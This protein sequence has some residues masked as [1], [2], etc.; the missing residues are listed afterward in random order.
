MVLEKNPKTRPIVRRL[1]QLEDRISG[2]VF[3]KM[4]RVKQIDSNS[5]GPAVM[6]MLYS[7]Y[8]VKVSQRGLIASL[9]AKNKIKKYGLSV[10]D[11]ARASKITGKGAFNFWRKA[12]GK[13]SDLNII[14]NKYKHP[15]AVEW[16]GVFYEE[17]DEDSGHYCV[18]T[19]VD[20]KAGTLRLADPYSHF[21]GVD[22]K[23][24][25]KVFLKR[26][27]DKNE[28]KGRTLVDRR[29]MFLITPKGESWPKKLGMVKV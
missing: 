10:R 23:F 3:P 1:L 17:E 21:A 9:R 29:V 19:R 15:V 6:A 11:M 7:Q 27:W 18:I 14:V 28:I 12:N 25:I 13:I 4:L 16:Q 26:W 20:K 24:E 22:R 2:A 5:C 8:G